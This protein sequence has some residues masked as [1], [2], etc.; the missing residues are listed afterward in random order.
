MIWFDGNKK[1]V[2]R[3]PCEKLSI[4]GYGET[5]RPAVESDIWIQSTEG[6]M[7][8]VWYRLRTPAEEY[9]RYH[10]PFLW[11]AQLAKHVV[12][13]ISTFQE[14]LLNHFRQG[15]YRWL[16][17]IYQSD[18]FIRLWLEQYG[19]KD[20]RQ[21]L[22]SQANFLWCQASQVDATLEKVP[23]WS[24]IHPVFL[25]SIPEQKE[26]E[27]KADMFALSDE[28]G[29][30]MTRR[31]TTV[32]PYVYK[33]FKH[34]PF[35]KFLYCQEPS[36]G[37]AEQYK[38]DIRP[39]S[40]TRTPA[41]RVTTQSDLDSPQQNAAITVGDV[42]SLPKD[43]LTTWK[44]SDKEWYGYVQKITKTTEGCQLGVLWL[45]RPSD[46][47]CLKVPYPF[48]KE[49]FLSDHCN[50]GDSPIYAE[51]VVRRP[52]VAFFGDPATTS[53]EFFVRQRYIEG[54]GA[55]QTLQGSHFQCDCAAEKPVFNYSNGV[56]LLV[57]IKNV[58]EPVVLVKQEAD[59]IAGKVKV[60]RLLRRKGEYGDLNAEP[61]ELV[62]THRFEIIPEANVYRE[63]HVRFYSEDEKRQGK[64]PPPYNRQGTGDFYYITS[65]DLQD[66]D[67]GL[68]P[69]AAPSFAYL[70]EGWDPS[71]DPF[72]PPLKGLDM[73]CGGG[74]FGHG[75]E[76]GGAVVFVSAVDL[77]NE[78]IHTYKA[79]LKPRNDTELFRGSVNDYLT[80]AMQGKGGRGVAQRGQVEMIAAGSPCPGFSDANPSKGNDRS[81]LNCSLAASVVAFVDFYRPKYA[82]MENVTG[83]ARGPDTENM[84]ALIVSALVGMGYQVRTFGL[85]A[86]NFGSPQ[87]R[88]RVFI[89][90]AAPGMIALPEPP[91]THSHPQNVSAASLAKLANGLRASAR[92]TTPTPFKYITAAEATKDL[93][94]TDARTSCISFPTHR[95][96]R[97]LSTLDRIRIG[98]VPRFPGGSTFLT[99]CDRGYMPQAQVDAYNWDVDMKTR[100][101]STRWQRVRRDGLMPTVLTAPHPNGVSGGTILHWDEERLLTIME[102]RRAQGFNDD[103]VLIGLPKEQWKIVGNSVARPVALA[104]GVSLRKAWLA[105]NQLPAETA[106]LDECEGVRVSPNA[107]VPPKLSTT[108]KSF[109]E[110]SIETA[111]AASCSTGLLG[112]HPNEN[113]LP[114]FV[115]LKRVK[116]SFIDNKAAN[117]AAETG[118]IRQY[119][120]ETVGAPSIPNGMSPQP[121]DHQFPNYSKARQPSLSV[122]PS[123]R[124]LTRE[125]TISKVT[126]ETTTTIVREQMEPSPEL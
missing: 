15:F 122:N 123:P 26:R 98:S 43:K 24:E 5:Y 23:V 33:C 68:Q 90:I 107:Q 121:G 87:S 126:V 110:T 2:Q 47:P 105:N 27:T 13:F 120:S 1:Y 88:S 8:N 14:V 46:T 61:N 118:E 117:M 38:Q 106:I 50:C 79:N 111:D 85:D 42:V 53:V 40:R 4:G 95:M 22:A 73:F 3:V 82:L 76:E 51:E 70:K 65:H 32:T 83:M 75:L 28:G 101:G 108:G 103:D 41:I 7:Y 112:H 59:R 19:K 29:E 125:T 17:S 67:S 30:M 49:L 64:I 74:N 77:Y 39:L 36:V 12:D 56:T 31:R 44:S 18:D 78:A 16:K 102:V 84:L 69:L 94:S 63:C 34:L 11:M 48:H 37:S 113:L 115:R 109:I 52:R 21:V 55:W 99:A 35:E 93:P 62:L 25:S 80:Q 57:H 86:W 96:S 119:N 97:N 81:L 54:D 89:S 58:L 9:R 100:K 72:Q 71:A 116:P 66:D 114:N 92:Y 45:Y 6:K 10:E 124:F 104:L 60:R 20:F 91:H